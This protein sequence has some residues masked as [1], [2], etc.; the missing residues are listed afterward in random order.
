MNYTEMHE[1]FP[2]SELRD[3]LSAA[4]AKSYDDEAN[5]QRT[6]GPLRSTYED[7]FDWAIDH[8]KEEIKYF[9]KYIENIETKKAIIKLIE[10]NGWKEHDVSEDAYNNTPYRNH[11]CFLGT[12]DELE[13]LHHKIYPQDETR[14]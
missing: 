9:K 6:G 3:F 5:N 4:M 8:A 14:T 10:M 1:G 11:M 12:E 2:L 7:T 13:E